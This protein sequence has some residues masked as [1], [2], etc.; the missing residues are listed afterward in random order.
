VKA[1]RH[2]AAHPDDDNWIAELIGPPPLAL[3]YDLL[4]ADHPLIKTF[5]VFGPAR[6][7]HR[8]RRRRSGAVNGHGN[9]RALA[10]APSPIPLGCKANSVE[11]LGPHTIGLIFDE[12]SNGPDQV[13]LVPLRF[14]I[15]SGC[16]Q[17]HARLIYDALG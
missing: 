11:P 13:L 6:T 1:A 15:A 14:G 10:R 5:A 7:S 16:R 8:S 3:P 4:P 9:A 17:R 2:L 12:Q